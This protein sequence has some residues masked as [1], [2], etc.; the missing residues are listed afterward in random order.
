VADR[1]GAAF[2]G[3]HDLELVARAAAG[4]LTPGEAVAARDLIASC[5]VCAALAADLRAIAAATREFGA[6]AYRAASPPAPRDFR[7]T[8]TDAARLRRRGLFGL[9][10]FADANRGRARGLGGALAALGLVGLLV[11]AGMP[12]LFLGAGGAAT[13]ESA[14]GAPVPEA[15]APE[16]AAPEPAA[17]A[18]GI[19]AP[20]STD[21]A[22]KDRASMAAELAPAATD[23]YALEAS[24]ETTRLAD[25]V[26]D[27]DTPTV[28]GSVILAIGSIGVLVAGFALL[29]ASRGR[30]RAGP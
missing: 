18:A 10:R 11:S 16:A 7:L 3:A 13:S 21:G 23:A 8:E 20:D 9:E 19:A 22:S 27:D 4:D 26:Q 28:G 17:G 2:H 30:A 14:G 15:A 29:L 12:S 1:L 5:D 25:A 6:A 24:G